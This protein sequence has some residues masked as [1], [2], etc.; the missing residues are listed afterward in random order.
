MLTSSK[1]R[2]GTVQGVELP[3]APL[4]EVAATDRVSALPQ[5]HT[6]LVEGSQ[7]VALQHE[8]DHASHVR[9]GH[10]GA[11]HVHVEIFA[12]VADPWMVELARLGR[13]DRD[14]GCAEVRLRAAILGRPP[15]REASDIP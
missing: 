12:A 2:D 7:V 15:G 5:V 8:G 14:T 3:L 11:W 10:A 13:G 9:R 4:V 1:Q 6:D